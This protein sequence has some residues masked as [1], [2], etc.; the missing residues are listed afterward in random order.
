MRR[1]STVG[2]AAAAGFGFDVRVPIGTDK[3]GFAA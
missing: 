2:T 3:L 1:L